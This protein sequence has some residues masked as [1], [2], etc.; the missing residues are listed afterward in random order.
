MQSIQKSPSK[1]EMI[2]TRDKKK[3]LH[4][5]TL[6][7]YLC[8]QW[9]E[10]IIGTHNSSSEIYQNAVKC[11]Q[12]LEQLTFIDLLTPLIQSTSHRKYFAKTMT[13]KISQ[14]IKCR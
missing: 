7:E 9:H 14:S 13:P 12:S 8:T 6:T 2:G 3:S 10:L 4:N 5:V 11:T 1:K